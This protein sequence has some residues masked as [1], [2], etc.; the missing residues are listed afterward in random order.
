MLS[1]FFA[2]DR[3]SSGKSSVTMAFSVRMKKL[4]YRTAVFKTGPDF[5][6]P[7]VLSSAVKSEVKNLDSYLIPGNALEEWLLGSYAGN[8][9]A[10]VVESAMGLYDGESYYIAKKFRLPVVLVMDCRRI[11]STMASLVYGLKNYKKGINVCGVILNNISSARHYDIISKEIKENVNGI[12][13][14]GYIRRNEAAFP[15]KERHL[16]LVTPDKDTVASG[17][18]NAKVKGIEEAVFSSVD[19]ELMI[20]TLEKESSGFMEVIE[21]YRC[22]K[23]AK[24]GFKQVSPS[25]SKRKGKVKIA[26]ALDNAFFFYYKFNLEILK[27]FGAEINFF[28]PLSDS[29]LPQGTKA[30]YIGGG[31]PEIYAG[32]LS[33][34]KKIAG[35]IYKFFANN[36]IIYAECGGLVYLCKNLLYGGNKYGFTGIF[37]FTATMDGAGLSLGYR[38]ITL[39]GET[40]MGKPGI[41]ARGHEFHYSKIIEPQEKLPDNGSGVLKILRYEN[42]FN[43][44]TFKDEG[45]NALNAVGSYVHLSFYSNKIIAGN[46]VENAR[47]L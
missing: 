46:I 21:N 14:F 1:V 15:I 44:G 27:S 8:N 32:T 39:T 16:G 18:F 26:V 5:I 7:V 17:D 34:N 12:G 3:S 24:T 6:D 38:S 41:K 30:I 43:P 36:G 4:G 20:K 23:I 25:P 10:F 31:Y 45:Y 42:P 40:F 9:D 19:I 29:S 37:P 2:S 13:V 28:S 11:S 22:K 33:G 47:N 35:E